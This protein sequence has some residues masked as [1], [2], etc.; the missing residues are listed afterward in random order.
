MNEQ[1][2]RVLRCK[3]T[4]DIR[5]KCSLDLNKLFRGPEQRCNFEEKWQKFLA[6]HPHNKDVYSLK[7]DTLEYSSEQLIPKKMNKKPA[8]LLVLGNP[9]TQ[10]I[11]SRMF[12]SYEGDRKEHRFWKDILRPANICCLSSEPESSI[13]E[14]NACLRIPDEAGHR[15]RSKAATDSDRFRPPIPTQ[16]GH[17]VI[18]ISRS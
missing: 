4:G 15:F 14:L 9:A 6:S 16:S 18:R 1:V 13:E 3:P 12:F 10:S 2:D 8:L 7:G 17:P 11:K 5:L